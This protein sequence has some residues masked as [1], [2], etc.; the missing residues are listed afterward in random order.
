MSNQD[1]LAKTIN[2]PM[3][4]KVLS[5]A[6]TA[7]VTEPDSSMY[8]QIRFDSQGRARC[9]SCTDKHDSIDWDKVLVNEKPLP[10][11]EKYM[12]WH[13][14]VERYPKEELHEY[15]NRTDFNYGIGETVQVNGHP[16]KCYKR[17]VVDD[18]LYQYFVRGVVTV[19]YPF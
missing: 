14:D 13:E 1:L 3:C 18:K 17:E 7:R 9:K 11:I 16:Y 6:N 15:G 8:G 19:V 10:V 5:E 4:N 12:I 2:C